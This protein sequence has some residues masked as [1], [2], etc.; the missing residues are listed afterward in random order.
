MI[1]RMI[2]LLLAFSSSQVFCAETED[3]FSPFSGF[4]SSSS[5]ELCFGPRFSKGEVP[6]FRAGERDSLQ[7]G[8]AASWSPAEAV[9][10]RLAADA[11]WV[12]WPDGSS[13][14]GPG[15]IRLG[16]TARLTQASSWR[17]ELLLDW[18]VKLPNSPDDGGLGSDE[19]D[20]KL[21]LY[22]LWSIAS[23]KVGLASGLYILGDPL[24]FA[25]QDDAAFLA[26]HLRRTG[27]IGQISTS[28]DW[29]LASARN[30]GVAQILA[31]GKYEGLPDPLWVG[32]D[33]ALGLTPAAADWQAGLRF[34]LGGA[35]RSE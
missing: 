15:D 31:A 33:G 35:C 19:T 21:G 3:G 14:Y 12:Q 18:V 32:V 6:N 30:P 2:G 1:F 16:T 4:S 29:R 25:N 34:G 23:W 7:M 17:P 24:Q 13:A 27:R 20:L 28:L 5:C 8:L 22:G 9:A 11:L 26:F 10:L